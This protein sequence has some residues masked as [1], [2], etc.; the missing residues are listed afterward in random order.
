MAEKEGG[1]KGAVSNHSGALHV[2]YSK[3]RNLDWKF[4][5]VGENL[6]GTLPSVGGVIC[7]KGAALCVPLIPFLDDSNLLVG[8]VQALM[9]STG[10][11]IRI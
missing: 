5:S 7:S 4:T 3:P 10:L 2:N 6:N 1:G 8:N 11:R 9:L